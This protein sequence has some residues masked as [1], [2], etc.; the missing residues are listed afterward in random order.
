MSASLQPIRERARA[1]QA[2]IDL[3]AVSYTVQDLAARWKIAESTVRDIPRDRLP[4]MEFGRGRKLK[5]RRYH[6]AD[7][8]AYEASEREKGRSQ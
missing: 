1:H 2:E 5:R 4:Y 3:A 6:P 8:L 7:V